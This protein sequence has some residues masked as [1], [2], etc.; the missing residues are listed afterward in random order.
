MHSG[1]AWVPLPPCRD[2]VQRPCVE[3]TLW[4]LSFSTRYHIPSWMLAFIRE[5]GDSEPGLPPVP[6]DG[7]FWFCG[8]LWFL[9]VAHE[10]WPFPCRGK[11][12]L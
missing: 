11:G 9:G 3:V 6:K 2:G 10:K 12:S 5:E 8:V 7:I 1:W 4:S